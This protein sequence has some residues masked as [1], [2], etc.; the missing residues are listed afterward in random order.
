[1]L[2]ERLVEIRNGIGE[3]SFVFSVNLFGVIWK[4]RLVKVVNWL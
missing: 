2:I 4:R 1:L 3:C